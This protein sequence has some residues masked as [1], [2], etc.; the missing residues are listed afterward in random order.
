MALGDDPDADKPPFEAVSRR[1][2]TKSAKRSAA[3]VR[4]GKP[5]DV[6]A[7]CPRLMFFD[8]ESARTPP[9]FDLGSSRT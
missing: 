2:E 3:P 4:P 7:R 8:Q 9:T 1:L 5:H 6:P